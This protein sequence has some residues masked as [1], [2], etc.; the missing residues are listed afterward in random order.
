MY[1]IYN[2]KNTKITLTDDKEVVIFTY[3]NWS[4]ETVTLKCFPFS[5]LPN[6]IK[7]SGKHS[8]PNNAWKLDWTKY[9]DSKLD[10]ENTY[11]IPIVGIPKFRS[12]RELIQ[13]GIGSFTRKGFEHCEQS[14]SDCVDLN[15]GFRSSEGLLTVLGKYW[16]YEYPEETWKGYTMRDL[17][18]E[19]ISDTNI[20]INCEYN[21][22]I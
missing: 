16:N 9:Y 4:G 11:G 21:N 15:A 13:S 5:E 19:H 20:L 3:T 6:L 18:D 22:F 1:Y 8:N 12:N 14:F 10:L 17:F 7:R 2:M